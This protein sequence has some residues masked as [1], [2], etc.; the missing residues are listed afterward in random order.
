MPAVG[1]KKDKI[2]F[3]G[4]LSWSLDLMTKLRDSKGRWWGCK[5]NALECIGLL[6]PFLTQSDL[7]KNQFVILYVDNISLIYAWEKKYCKNDEET[8]I[9]I[10]CLYV[11]ES[12]LEAKVFVEHVKRK[13]ND[14]AVPVDNLSRKS[15]TT[16]KDLADINDVIWLTPS[17]SLASWAAAPSLDWCL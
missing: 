6:I 13:S 16:D 2:F 15:T 5:S 12:F 9:L 4:G 17:R 3:V 7:L 10:R 1:F 11:L 8:S 14:M